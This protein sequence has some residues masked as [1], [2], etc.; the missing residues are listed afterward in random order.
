MSADFLALAVPGVQKLSPYVTGKPIEELARELGM[1]PAQ[2]VKLASNENPLGPS[3]RAL[4]AI[5][6]ALPE[7]RTMLELGSGGGNNA[8]FLK[9]NFQ[10]TLVDRSPAM[11]EM[12]RQ[13][14]PELPHHTGDMRSVRLD[15]TFDAVF[16]H[17]AVMYMHTE[18]DLRAAMQTAYAHLR[19]GG[20]ILM[21]PDCTKETY[22]PN[23]EVHG[24]DGDAVDPPIPGRAVR[25]MEWTYDPD[26][27]DTTA[28]EEFVYLL[29][30]GADD[31]RSV[32]DRH[33]F[34]LFPKATWLRLLEEVGF[35]A[36]ALPFDHSEVEGITDMFLGKKTAA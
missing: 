11:L 10:V 9:Q 19:P 23:A 18:A 15:Q 28:V 14:N 25:Y 36:Q 16:I 31:V 20:I 21:V 33:I 26:P 35:T 6:D 2:I 22:R 7:A 3:P 27:D 1:D 29:R 30:E 12:S 5:Q 13:L 24:T 8:S 34:G 4:A 32:Y 17:D